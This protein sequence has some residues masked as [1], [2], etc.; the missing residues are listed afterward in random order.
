MVATQTTTWLVTGASRG[1][2]LEIVRQLTATESNLV[3]ATARNPSTASQ[4]SALQE[5]IRSLNNLHVIQL[6]ANDE[7][8]MRASVAQVQQILGERGLDVLYNNAGIVS[9]SN[10]FGF[11]YA[12]LP[13]ILQTN[14]VAPAFLGELFL[15]LLERGAR[16]TIVNVSSSLGSIGV[17]FGKPY[18]TYSLTK[19]ALNMLSYKQAKARS[20]LIVISLCPGHCKT[21]MGGPYATLEPSESV[22]GQ[23]RLVAGLKPEHTG[24][25]WRYDGEEV[26]W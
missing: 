23:L 26:P 5:E 3:I 1:L 24:R 10:V 6:D 15:P 14:V 19:T 7:K 9:I 4:L 22:A 11:E 2:G 13:K 16:K 20:D 12:N 21:E 18:P 25:F 8:S 17:N